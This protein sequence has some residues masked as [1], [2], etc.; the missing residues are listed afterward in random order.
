MYIC[1]YIYMWANVSK[2]R[3]RLNAA[4]LEHGAGPQ[5]GGENIL[6]QRQG[7]CKGWFRLVGEHNSNN[8]R[9]WYL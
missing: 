6:L 4:Y 1:M 5:K 2:Y 8:Y 7:W 9:L 3:S